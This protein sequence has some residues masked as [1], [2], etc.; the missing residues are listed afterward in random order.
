MEIAIRKLEK[1]A[2]SPQSFNHDQKV[3]I[4]IG[5]KTL[6]R[7]MGE[8]TIAKMTQELRNKYGAIL[9]SGDYLATQLGKKDLDDLIKTYIPS[10]IMSTN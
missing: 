7:T 5:I 2:A 10:D 8:G 9:S 3:E 1:W 6:L 4:L